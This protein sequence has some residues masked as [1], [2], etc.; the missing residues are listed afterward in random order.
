MGGNLKKKERKERKEK[1]ERVRQF[2]VTS[3]EKGRERPSPP[4]TRRLK[5]NPITS[6]QSTIDH[7]DAVSVSD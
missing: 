6:Q 5:S 3:R 7:R 2:F 1:S 4:P